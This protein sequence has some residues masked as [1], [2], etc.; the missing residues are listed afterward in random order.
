MS[1]TVGFIVPGP[2]GDGTWVDGALAGRA[3]LESSGIATETLVGMPDAIPAGWAVAVCHGGQYAPLAA[4]RASASQV[5]IVSDCGVTA[6]TARSVTEIDW[7]WPAAFYCAGF[8][9]RDLVPPDHEVCFIAGA[10]VPTQRALVD[11]F[12]AGM[13]DSASQHPGGRALPVH[14]TYLPSFDDAATALS[15]V[16]TALGTGR[17]ALFVS[18]SDGA[19]MTA[20]ELARTAGAPTVSFLT[21]LRDGDLGAVVCDIPGILAG[22]V[23]TALS[24]ERLPG[25]V[26]ATLG[27]GQVALLLGPAA[28]GR[29]R[30]SAARAAR[31]REPGAAVRLSTEHAAVGRVPRGWRASVD[32][33]GEPAGQR[34]GVPGHDRHRVEA[35][36]RGRVDNA[37][38]RAGRQDKHVAGAQV[39]AV[40]V[41]EGLSLAPQ[42]H[43]DLGGVSMRVR[44]LRAQR[45][46][47]LEEHA[48]IGAVRRP[49]EGG[50][51]DGVPR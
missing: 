46:P 26:T 33:R 40:L 39:D 5:V 9:V 13:L 49:D 42:D 6:P 24:G 16:R 31:I 44:R 1:G 20:L 30:E 11:A 25:R 15:S 8:A 12:L 21:G 45:L 2:G 22:L 23:R 50:E 35:L 29:A 48:G 37:V 7:G 27:S 47:G 14:V 18:S 51:A 17:P 19:G 43:E 34:P 28:S 3:A 41:A 10:A 38:H 4:A 36:G 32:E